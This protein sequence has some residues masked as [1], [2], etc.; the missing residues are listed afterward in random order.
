MKLKTYS[1][2]IC[3]LQ[4]QLSVSQDVNWCTGVVWITCDVVISCLDS[5]SDGTHSLQ[6]IHC[7]TSDAMLHFSKSYIETN[8]STSW[9][10]RGWVNHQHIFSFG[11]TI[12]LRQ[13]N[14]TR[15]WQTKKE[16][17]EDYYHGEKALVPE[18]RKTVPDA[19]FENTLPSA[20]MDISKEQVDNN[21]KHKSITREHFTLQRRWKADIR[22][23]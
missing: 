19:P 5:H 2:W 15:K 8:S 9:M 14:K 22:R 7:W 12:P 21:S 11:W 6:S 4:T 16:N 10:T 20:N 1:K 23:R 3:F 17:D 18:L 13:G